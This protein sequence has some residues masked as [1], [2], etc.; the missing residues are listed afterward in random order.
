MD[1]YLIKKA[2]ACLERILV[3]E[4]DEVYAEKDRLMYRIYSIK[5]RKRIGSVSAEKFETYI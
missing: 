3:I 4:G 1:K 2:F 5:T